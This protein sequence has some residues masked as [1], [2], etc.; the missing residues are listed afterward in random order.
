VYEAEGEDK[1]EEDGWSLRICVVR[2]GRLELLIG[3]H[4]PSAL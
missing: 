1:S 3:L 4:L 2:L